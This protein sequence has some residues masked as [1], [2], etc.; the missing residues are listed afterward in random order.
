MSSIISFPGTPASAPPKARDCWWGVK[1]KPL[2]EIEDLETIA[3]TVVLMHISADTCLR[4]FPDEGSSYA[5]HPR[6]STHDIGSIVR[7]YDVY[8]VNDDGIV[9]KATVYIRPDFQWIVDR[10]NAIIRG[11]HMDP[12]K[13]P[14]TYKGLAMVFNKHAH[15]SPKF[16]DAFSMRVS[17]NLFD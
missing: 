15:P 5:V 14:E 10:I 1:Y 17:G 8:A 12:E 4:E 11:G 3:R 7:V 16:K 6:P 9:Y 13:E 2:G